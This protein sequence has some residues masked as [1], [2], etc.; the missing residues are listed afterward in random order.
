MNGKTWKKIVV[1]ISIVLGSALVVALWTGSN[2][3][4]SLA[5]GQVYIKRS[6]DSLVLDVKEN[7]RL[8]FQSRDRL[9]GWVGDR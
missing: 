1:G 3:I 7:R 8:L 5:T 4:A 2:Q 9:P 6:L